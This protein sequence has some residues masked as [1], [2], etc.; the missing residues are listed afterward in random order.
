MSRISDVKADATRRWQQALARYGWLDHAVRAWERFR[1]NNAGQYAAA[2]TY[3]SFLALFPLLLLAVSVLGFVLHSNPDLLVKLLNDITDN[4]P[5]TVGRQLTSALN[6]VIKSRTGLGLIGGI[7]VLFAGL[8]WIGNLRRA[9]NA[10]WGL[11]RRQQNPVLAKVANLFVLAGL[12]FAILVSLGLSTVET[13]VTEQI[14]HGLGIDSVTAVTLLV[15]IVAITIAFLGDLLIL[16]WL[17]IRLPGADVPWSVAWRTAVLAAVGF[18]ILKIVGTYTIAKSAQ[19]VTL[20]PFAS[21]L[22]VL[23]WIQLV[24]RYLLYCTAWCA[25]AVPE[26]APPAPDARQQFADP[27]VQGAESGKLSGQAASA[28]TL[29]RR[30]FCGRS[31]VRGRSAQPAAPLPAP[32]TRARSGRFRRVGQRRARV[33]D[34]ERAPA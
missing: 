28:R 4:F 21:L 31:G 20:G 3:F 24:V 10:V 26:P 9:I 8:G 25:T 18:E 12:G 19:S 2:I 23:I 6:A 5:G 32:L 22:A 7:G 13:A 27:A 14:V 11:P 33:D 1:N 15:K 30:R 29:T 16:G 17:L 34:G